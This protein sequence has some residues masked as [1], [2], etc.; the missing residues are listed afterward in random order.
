M[1]KNICKVVY[2]PDHEKSDEYTVIVNQAEVKVKSCLLSDI[3]DNSAP[4]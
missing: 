2:K 3:D 4:S 1:V